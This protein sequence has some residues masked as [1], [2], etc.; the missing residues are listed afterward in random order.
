LTLLDCYDPDLN[1]PPAEAL[2]EFLTEGL[3]YVRVPKP[4][5]QRLC[6]LHR[7]IGMRKWRDIMNKSPEK[8][9]VWE[10]TWLY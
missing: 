10:F 3:K 4:I 5:F 7:A 6:L 2:I 9:E 1:I 8:V